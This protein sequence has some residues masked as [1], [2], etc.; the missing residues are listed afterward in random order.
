MERAGGRQ[1][2]RC[3]LDLGIFLPGGGGKEFGSVLDFL[4]SILSKWKNL[5]PPGSEANGNTDVNV[6]TTEC[7][8]SIKQIK[9][10]FKDKE[11][12]KY[13]RKKSKISQKNHTKKGFFLRKWKFCSKVK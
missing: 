11:K 9:Q 2:F 6:A 5:S 12:I 13:F 3:P 1:C 8:L 10:K 7:F 4:D